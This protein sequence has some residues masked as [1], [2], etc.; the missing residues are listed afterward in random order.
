MTQSFQ[1][2]G[3]TASSPAGPGGGRGGL[4][5]P[6][7]KP[8]E[9]ED[10]LNRLLFHPFSRRLARALAPTGTSPNAVS[11]AGAL[12][13]AAAAAAYTGLG[14]P[15]SVLVGFLLHM[16]WHVVDGAD[17]DL[18]RM[19]GKAS[20]VGELVD[21][22]CDYAGH[23]ILYVALAAFLD[24]SIGLWAWPLATAAAFSRAAQSNHAESERRTYLWRA[25]GV[26]WLQHAHASGDEL[27]RRPGWHARLLAGLGSGYVRLSTAM[28]PHSGAVEAAVD[29]CGDDPRQKLRIHR[30]CRTASRRSLFLHSLL[31]ANPRTILLGA[32][33]ALASPLYFFIVECTLMNLLLATSIAQQNA[34]NRRLAA[35]LTGVEP[36]R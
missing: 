20:P 8:R 26:P 22:A 11:V 32:S 14:W 19:T 2:A 3:R 35:K 1:Q 21:G 9:L 33:M 5:A 4:P 15:E 36:L 13:V 30:L 10:P 34:C 18:A 17:G 16:S 12:I 25:Y 31:G 23:G 6:P 7:V 27:F 29:R 24:D 28:S